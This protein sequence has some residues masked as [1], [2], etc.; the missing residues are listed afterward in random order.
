MKWFSKK[1]D[2]KLLEKINSKSSVK[3]SVNKSV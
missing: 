3:E 1:N 2:L